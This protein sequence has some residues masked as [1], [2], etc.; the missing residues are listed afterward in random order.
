MVRLRMNRANPAP[1]SE[2][3]ISG[4][5]SGG[6]VSNYENVTYSFLFFFF[7]R[8]MILY[9]HRFVILYFYSFDSRFLNINTTVLVTIVIRICVFSSNS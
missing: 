1:N 6:R 2:K 7:F 4:E 3:N 8:E 9:T 5:V